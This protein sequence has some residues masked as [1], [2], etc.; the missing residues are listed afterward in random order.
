MQFAFVKKYQTATA[1]IILAV[2]VMVFYGNTLINGFVMD[3]TLVIEG[4]EY[5]HSLRYLPKVLTGCTWEHAMGGCEGLSHYYRPIF[6]L[7]LLLTYQ[8]SSQPWFFHLVNI[9]LF[10]GVVVLIFFFIK[11]LTHNTLFAFLS[12]L[13][14]LIHP[15]NAEVVNWPS[16]ASDPLHIVFI[17]A[18]LILYI[19]WRR[20]TQKIH[21]WLAYLFYF[22]AMLSKEPAIIIV[23]PLVLALDLIIF[24]MPIKKLFA[25][26]QLQYYALFAMPLAVYIAMRGAVIGLL[27]GIAGRGM[28]VESFSLMETIQVFFNLPLYSLKTILYVPAPALLFHDFPMYDGLLS[29]GFFLSFLACIGAVAL[30]IFF[31]RTKKDIPAFAMVWF[32]I[33][34]APMLI[35]FYV[36]GHNVFAERFLFASTIGIS[37]LAAYVLA[38]LWGAKYIFNA[39]A[40]EKFSF[41]SAIS[42]WQKYSTRRGAVVTVLAVAMAISWFTVFSENQIW[43]NT[44]TLLRANLERTPSAFHLQEYLAGELQRTGDADGARREYEDILARNPNYRDI[45]HIYNNLAEYAREAGEL[46]KAEEYYQKAI[47][48]SGGTSY[49]AYN[50]FGAFYIEQERYLDAAAYLCAA[51]FIDPQAPEPQANMSRVATMIEED[52]ANTAQTLHDGMMSGSPFAK[53]TDEILRYEKRVCDEDTCTFYFSAQ[54]EA[55]GAVLPFLILGTSSGDIFRPQNPSFDPQTGEVTLETSVKY[56]DEELRFVFPACGGTYYSIEVRS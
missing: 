15:R 20:S 34:L 42:V 1:L 7:A 14:F 16:L 46:A 5:I 51:F 24:R 27:G 17:L 28:A 41:L 40:R 50:N 47:E 52:E 6:S 55:V 36:A 53:S 4:N 10:G 23:P 3:D 13:L 44:V 37:M 54:S 32:F 29:G 56:E 9:V 30:A 45:D 21:I 35:F 25:L 39:A 33:S 31:I 12:A 19:K 11:T 43:K 18:A 2:L 22:F 8:I 26:K 38:H 49:K 48:V